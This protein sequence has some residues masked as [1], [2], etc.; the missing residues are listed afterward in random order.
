MRNPNTR[1]S[2]KLLKGSWSKKKE[3]TQQGKKA[4]LEEKG[5]STKGRPPKGSKAG[6]TPP[7]QARPSTPPDHL[8]TSQKKEAHIGPIP[9]TSGK[10]KD[11]TTPFRIPKRPALFE[12]DEEESNLGQGIDIFRP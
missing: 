12:P 4:T 9:S 10:Q 1:D 8:T 11:K 2:R 3:D 6:P 7:K 5:K